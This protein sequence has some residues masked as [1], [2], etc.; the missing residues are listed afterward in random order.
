MTQK[1]QN[2]DGCISYCENSV[3]LWKYVNMLLFIVI[4]H[5][6][7]SLLQSSPVK[8]CELDPI[9][10]WLLRDS[11]GCHKPFSE[12]WHS[13]SS[14]EQSAR[15]A[16]TEKQGLDK[17]VLNMLVDKGVSVSRSHMSF[18][19]LTGGEATQVSFYLRKGYF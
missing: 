14:S 8:S 13:T 10:I 6:C 7:I 11:H 16:T 12:C 19:L 18:Y 5:I 15:Q 4:K 1:N 17:S 3:K 9:P 2:S